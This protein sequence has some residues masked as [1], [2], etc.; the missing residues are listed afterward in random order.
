MD[1]YIT[2][3]FVE[4]EEI[5]S[6]PEEDFGYD[7]ENDNRI[8]TIGDVYWNY[9]E[10]GLVNIDVMIQHLE[11]LKQKG[12][13]YVGCEWHCDHGEMELYGFSMKMSSKPEIDEYLE[14]IKTKERKKKEAEI[15]LLE[16]KV[17]NLKKSLV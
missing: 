14:E 3:K 7:Y 5:Y 4:K 17:K 13:N 2:T 9:T 16:D 6:R 11:D 12:S 15:K 8:E 1:F 10:S